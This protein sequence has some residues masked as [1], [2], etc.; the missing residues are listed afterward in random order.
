M[1]GNQNSGGARPGAGRIR[2]R[3]TL[4]GPA[5]IYVREV[6]RSRFKRKDVTDQEMDETLDMMVAFYAEHHPVEEPTAD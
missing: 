6:A 2:T 3:Y 1:A 5:A 4:N